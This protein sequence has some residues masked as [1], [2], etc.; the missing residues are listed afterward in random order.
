MYRDAL[1]D[2]KKY[3]LHPVLVKEN[4]KYLSDIYYDETAMNKWR[5]T[6]AKSNEGLKTKMDKIDKDFK[7]AKDR[8]FDNPRSTDAS[9]DE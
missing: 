6:C 2:L 9:L 5:D 7:A 1:E 3:E 8:V 4:K